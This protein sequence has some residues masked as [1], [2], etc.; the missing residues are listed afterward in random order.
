MF[1]YASMGIRNN[2]TKC[3]AQLLGTRTTKKKD[4]SQST[5]NEYPKFLW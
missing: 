2:F 1:N 5:W 4:T 3:Q